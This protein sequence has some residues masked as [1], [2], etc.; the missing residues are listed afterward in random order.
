MNSTATPS[1][2][3]KSLQ[4]LSL[5]ALGIVFGDIGTSPLYAFEQVFS[6]GIHS[7]PISQTNIFGVLSLFFWSL[8]MIVTVKYVFFMMR[9]D[10]Q[11]EG[12]IMALMALALGKTTNR[13][14]AQSLLIILGLVGAAF[15]YGDGVITPAISVLSAVEGMELISPSLKDWVLPVSL[16]ILLALFWT[17]RRGTGT[18][19]LFFGPVMLIWFTLIGALGLWNIV[20]HPDVLKALNPLYA[21]DFLISHG[22]LA[23]FAL[24]AVVL[25]LTGAEALYADMGHFGS[26]PI[27]IVWVG[28]VFPALILNY[29]GQGALLM[30]KPEALSNLFYLMAPDFL[31]TPLIFIAT[32]ATVI[33]S[34]AVIS[35]AFSMT[36]Q[37]AQLG[38]L[39]R[40]RIAQTSADEIGQ[41]YVPLVNSILAILVVAV[42]LIFQNSNALGSAYGI[43]VTGTMLITDFLAI[44]VAIHIW[45]W[46]PLRAFCGAAFF[47]LIDA[48]FFSANTLKIVDGGWLPILLSVVM[49]IIMTT[50]NS[51]KNLLNARAQEVSVPLLDF[52]A[53][54]VSDDFPRTK[55]SAIYLVLDAHYAPMALQ[56]TMHLFGVLHQQVAVLS[57]RFKLIPYVQPQDRVNIQLC[58]KGFIQIYL[59][60]GFM[61][62]NDIPQLL[63]RYWPDSLIKDYQPI[64]FYIK[65][66]MLVPEGS[67]DMMFWRK[68]IYQ[69]MY[70]NAVQPL[71][72]FSLPVNDSMA[73]SVRMTL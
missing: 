61:D 24:G 70:R 56:R 29:F 16:G 40:L 30:D 53:N 65:R 46:R 5:A 8:M 72:F 59:N 6:N 63:E 37:A 2:Q 51:G 21:I 20:Q 64:S 17:Q 49:I 57:I 7:V 19:G 55:G 3:K 27:R 31:Q 23:F 41:I 44:T 13:P 11:G 35:G 73:V 33:A 60:C 48:V 47:I 32:L 42:I 34:Q 54:N 10:N 15:F 68:K 38:Y 67:R 14:R 39:P 22:A 25:C 43:A 1:P 58:D 66:L 45:K 12:G 4:A 62:I 69:F 52:I 50:W 9:A 71:E 28:L 26:L 18:I 36:R